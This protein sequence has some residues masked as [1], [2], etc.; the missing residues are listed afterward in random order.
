MTSTETS[1]AID[2][3]EACEKGAGKSHYTRE[4][5]RALIELA[6]QNANTSSE[7]KTLSSIRLYIKE[8]QKLPKELKTLIKKAKA[9]SFPL[10]TQ[11]IEGKGPLWHWKLKMHLQKNPVDVFLAPTSYI[12]PALSS[13]LPSTKSKASSPKIALVVHDLIAFFY[14]QH[15]SRFATWVERLTL[16]RAL[17]NANWI[18]TVSENTHKDLLSLYPKVKNNKHIL[19]PPAADA[20]LESIQSPSLSKTNSSKIPKKFLLAVG[21]LQPRKNIK[22]VLR[23]F[24]KLAPQQKD[25]HLCIAGGKGWKASSIVQA[26]PKQYQDRIHFLGYVSRPQLIELYQKAQ[27]LLFPSIYEGFGMPPL[28]AM[29]LGCPV[30]V[31]DNSALPEVVGNAG[32]QVEAEDVQQLIQAILKMQEPNA[33]ASFIEKGKRQAQKFSWEQSAKNILAQILN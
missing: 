19:A 24:E 17:K 8:G 4:V 2:Y 27:M 5:S 6:L 9:Q 15:N 1:L 30:V 31:S 23:A 25:L 21:T 10:T 13:L 20:L 18:I 26:I 3:R 16:S 14:S 11:A 32:V 28:E 22:T 12:Y 33:R 7:K 29:Q